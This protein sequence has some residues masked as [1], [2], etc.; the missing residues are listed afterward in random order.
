MQIRDVVSKANHQLIK[1][2]DGNEYTITSISNPNR[3]V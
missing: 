3:S 1:Y 2:T